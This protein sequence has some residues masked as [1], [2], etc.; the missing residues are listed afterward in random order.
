[1]E[2]LLFTGGTGFLGRTIKPIL[3]VDYVVTTCGITPEDE[4][5]IDR[6]IVLGRDMKAVMQ[7][8]ISSFSGN[9]EI[10]IIENWADIDGIQ[11]RPF[12]DGKIVLEYAGNIGRVQGLNRVI[13]QLIVDA[14]V[15]AHLKDYD[16]S[17]DL[18]MNLEPM[19]DY[20]YVPS[21]GGNRPVFGFNM[22]IKF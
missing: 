18:T 17:D 8:K 13:E 19:V 16:I 15:D 21:L 12:P 11:P 7:D 6:L 14:H 20:T 3:E 5:R 2:N 1:M 22:S 9:S 4:I 10:A